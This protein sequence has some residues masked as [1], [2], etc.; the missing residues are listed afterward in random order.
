MPFEILEADAGGAP[1]VRV[2][3]DAG[4]PLFPGNPQVWKQRIPGLLN[5]LQTM[6]IDIRLETLR[7]GHLWH[8][9][10][11]NH[12]PDTNLLVSPVMASDLML[13][14]GGDNVQARG[15]FVLP[16]D[17]IECVHQSQFGRD[18]ESA[19]R[20]SWGDPEED[21][22][23]INEIYGSF[24]SFLHVTRPLH[25]L[26]DL[27]FVTDRN[28]VCVRLPISIRGTDVADLMIRV[29]EKAQQFEAE[30][31]SH[32]QFLRDRRPHVMERMQHMMNNLEP[33]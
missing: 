28:V 5:F 17:P 8:S 9:Y 4:Y 7:H 3:L 26:Y 30:T 14:F 27:G 2:S 1:L 11:Q 10:L 29:A 13:F 32:I 23:L 19:D 31:S 24:E 16:L 22:N 12:E 18:L 20:H 15:S 25:S 21:D 6:R 33:V